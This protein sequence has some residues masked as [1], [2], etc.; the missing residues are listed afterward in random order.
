MDGLGEVIDVHQ[1]R[2]GA[3]IEAAGR[4]SGRLDTSSSTEWPLMA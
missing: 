2:G 4:V 1:Q 3:E